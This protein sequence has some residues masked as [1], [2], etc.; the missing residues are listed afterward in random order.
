M[1]RLLILIAVLMTLPAAGP[2]AAQVP[3]EPPAV[4]VADTIPDEAP[5]PR[6]AFIRAMIIPGW[7]HMYI[8][9]PRRG[10]VFIALQG[11]SWYMLVRTIT[12]LNDARVSARTLEELGRDSLY[13]SMAADTA[14]SRQLSNPV[15]FDEALLEYPGLEN[16]RGL[17]RTR[18][19]HRQDWIVYTLVLTF[20]G[21]VDAYVT[22]HLKE[23]PVD[24]TAT[25]VPGGGAS[26][27]LSVPAGRRR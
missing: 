9:E 13:A 10:A 2:V 16:A 6:N 27:Q 19:R 20:A 8:D 1:L 14:I 7:G 21:A 25:P 5:V 22:A 24:F 18:Q 26:L 12:R 4:P 11:T 3:G 23:F 15:A 17:A